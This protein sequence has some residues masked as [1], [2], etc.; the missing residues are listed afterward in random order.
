MTVN[1]IGMPSVSELRPEPYR[2][3]VG[4]Q[5]ATRNPMALGR[6]INAVQTVISRDGKSTYSHAGIILDREGTTFEALWTNKRQN[7]FEAYEGKR[8]V[9]A[10]CI[11]V[12]IP[13][14]GGIVN[15]LVREREGK[16]YPGYRL[17]FQLVPPVAKYTTFKG[18][19][20][21][22]S[23]LVALASYMAYLRVGRKDSG[24]YCWP[25]HKW[26]TGTTPDTLS[27]EWH[28]WKHWE[29][30]FEGFLHRELFDLSQGERK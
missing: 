17:P 12:S 11:M 8:V 2:L 6:A 30:I 20:L 16:W 7:L 19:F 29:I 26:Y 25:R 24:G 21:V 13:T 10:R 15:E 28:R 23:E 3:Q 1:S 9:I 27:D 14:W 5:F 18:K 4:D 22:C